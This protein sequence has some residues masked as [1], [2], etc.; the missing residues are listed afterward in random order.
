MPGPTRRAPTTAEGDRRRRFPRSPRARLPP[1]D[2]SAPRAESPRERHRRSSACLPSAGALPEIASTSSPTSSSSTFFAMSAWLTMPTRLCP[3]ITGSLRT[4]LS[5]IV[6]IASE[7]ESSAPIVTGLPSPSSPTLTSEG[8]LP[9][10]ITLTTM[11][12][13]LTT[14]LRRSSSPQIGSAPTPSSESFLAASAAVSLSP[15][16]SQS[17]RS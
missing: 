7:I 14:P 17:G 9:S 10:A 12:R 6:R 1:P 15:M 4:C 16:H 8:S 3:S 2:R 5:A 13:S 11:S